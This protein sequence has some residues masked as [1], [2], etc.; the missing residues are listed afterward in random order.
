MKKKV[1]AFF[2]KGILIGMADL[3]PGIS[4]G[5][6]AMVT[7]IY[8]K[9]LDNIRAV[10]ANI[11]FV[12]SCGSKSKGSVDIK[13]LAAVFL[14]G[15]IAIVSFTKIFAFVLSHSFYRIMLFSFFF[16]AMAAS[17]ILIAKKINKISPSVI[18]S[19][20]M[21]VVIALSITYLKKTDERNNRFVVKTKASDI[22]QHYTKNEITHLYKNNEMDMSQVVYR[23]I[24]TK[25]YYSNNDTIIY[26]FIIM[27]G[28]IAILAMMLPGIS[29]SSVLLLFGLYDDTIHFVNNI[30]SSHPDAISMIFI[31]NLVAGVMLGLIIFSKM[32]LLLLNKYYNTMIATIVGLMSVSLIYLWPF[33]QFFYVG[34]Y[35]NDKIVLSQLFPIMPSGML[36]LYSSICFS[37]GTL[38]FYMIHDRCSNVEMAKAI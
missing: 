30:L 6:M 4:G 12:L 21:G 7:G 23:D 5:T 22:N 15:F 34:N 24:Q 29:G 33:W 18:A 32:I 8:S 14:G 11:F 17:T 16:G 31:G 25:S 27:A 37:I 13:F 20:L 19:F 2:F 28:F 36:L 3:V 35:H 1:M 38:S 9:L 26:P 10:F